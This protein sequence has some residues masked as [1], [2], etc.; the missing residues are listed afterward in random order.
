M[1]ELQNEMKQDKR[2]FDYLI[3]HYE[4]LSEKEQRKHFEAIIARL[5][6]NEILNDTLARDIANA[7]VDG[8]NYTM[9]MLL[10][11]FDMLDL[12]DRT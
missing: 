7:L 8:E 6:V 2:F 5:C 1:K 10:A 9:P 12:E 4:R 3:S 11:H